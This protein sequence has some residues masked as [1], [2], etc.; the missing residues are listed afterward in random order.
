MKR[1]YMPRFK[2]CNAETLPVSS[3]K[4][5]KHDAPRSSATHDLAKPEAVTGIRPELNAITNYQVRH[6]Q[7][8]EERPLVTVKKLVT[9]RLHSVLMQQ[10][11][12]GSDKRRGSGWLS[13]IF[14][15]LTF[16]PVLYSSLLFALLAIIFGLVTF[17]RVDN[18]S[19]KYGGKG[20]AVLGML[21][22][23]TGVL[24]ILLGVIASV[25]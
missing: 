16:A 18:D 12:P 19:S 2:T 9:D 23:V 20:L 22:G 15:I 4:T 14:G 17:R 6:L 11:R 5:V 1:K 10:K 25:L 3:I 13:L 24:L 21:L 8:T 7:T